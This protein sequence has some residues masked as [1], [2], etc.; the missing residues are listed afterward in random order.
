MIILKDNEKKFYRV[1]LFLLGKIISGLIFS[2]DVFKIIALNHRCT[3]LKIQGGRWPL[4]LGERLRFWTI[5]LGFK[6]FG[7]NLKGVQY[8]VLN[9]IF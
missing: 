3:R 2:F 7:Q 4:N 8:F 6:L 9:Y 5:P 1:I